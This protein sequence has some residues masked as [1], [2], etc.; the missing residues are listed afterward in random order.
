MF[1]NHHQSICRKIFAG[2]VFNN[3][4]V[5]KHFFQKTRHFKIIVLTCPNIT[6]SVSSQQFKANFRLIFDDQW[7]ERVIFIRT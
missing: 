4:G 6:T 5:L 3:V 2:K 1:F 7:F